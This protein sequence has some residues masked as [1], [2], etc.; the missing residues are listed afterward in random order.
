M[1][2]LSK[3]YSLA[4]ASN[5]KTSAG[6]V[7][8]KLGLKKY[9]GVIVTSADASP[10]PDPAMIDLAL[11]KLGVAPGGAIFFGDNLEDLQAGVAAGVRTVRVNC[12]DEGAV[13][14]ILR[15]IERH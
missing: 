6:L 1:P 9:F 12:E 13:E 14:K 5:R 15:E 11:A 3:K 7:L 8:E 10:K 4:A 2:L